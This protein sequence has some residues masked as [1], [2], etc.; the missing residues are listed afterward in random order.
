MT[1][2]KENLW[3]GGGGN[4][5]LS[6]H[7]CH[8]QKYSTLEKV[9]RFSETFYTYL[10][11]LTQKACIFKKKNQVLLFIQPTEMKLMPTDTNHHT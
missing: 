4:F 8:L 6:A 3:G 2:K 1:V 9:T 11:H 5:I 10:W 7:F